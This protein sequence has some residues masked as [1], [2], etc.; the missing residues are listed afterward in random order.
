M[1]ACLNTLNGSAQGLTGSE[2]ADRLARLIGWG[3]EET[4]AAIDTLY[5]LPEELITSAS[6]PVFPAPPDMSNKTFRDFIANLGKEAK[7]SYET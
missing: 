2:T 4:L 7:T 6:G 3:V 1:L 5:D